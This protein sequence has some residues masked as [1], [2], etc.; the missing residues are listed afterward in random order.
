MGENIPRRIPEKALSPQSRVAAFLL[1]HRITIDETFVHGGVS[2]YEFT[3]LGARGELTEV[4]RIQYDTSKNFVL[5][6]DQQ[7]AERRLQT[8]GFMTEVAR[9]FARLLIQERGN[10]LLGEG[11][12]EIHAALDTIEEDSRPWFSH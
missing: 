9:P 11:F 10:F 1:S 8:P 3:R 4:G 12:E 6:M 5:P 7:E 2:T